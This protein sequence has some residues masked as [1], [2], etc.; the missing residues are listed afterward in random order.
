MRVNRKGQVT[1]PKAIRERLGVRGGGRLQGSIEG[2]RMVV[3]KSGGIEDL[4]RIL[5]KPK[6][7]RSLE[8]IDEGIVEGATRR[9]TRGRASQQ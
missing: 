2:D 1:L 6:R 7:T 3:A 8:E 5:P 9:R 4:F